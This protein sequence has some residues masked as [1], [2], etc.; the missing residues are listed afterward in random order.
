MKRQYGTQQFAIGREEE[1]IKKSLELKSLREVAKIYKVDD[2][3]VRKFLRKNNIRFKKP[4]TRWTDS[5]QQTLIN[6]LNEGKKHTEI[7]VLMNR[8]ISTVRVRSF[9][10]GFFKKA[11]LEWKPEEE[12]EFLNLLKQNHSPDEISWVLRKTFHSMHK[13]IKRRQIPHDQYWQI[14]KIIQ[15]SGHGSGNDLIR[16]LKQRFWT[17]KKNARNKN[18]EI[19]ITLKY[20]IELY[21]KQQGKCHYTG[22]NMEGVIGSKNSISVDRIDSNKGYTKDNVCLAM[23]K[24]NIA[25]NDL[26]TKEFLEMCYQVNDYNRKH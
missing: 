7:C 13:L 2:E 24:I 25:K 18:I 21:E 3:T 16:T 1:I 11:P 9:A 5:E 6:Y 19:D 12:V 4:N 22:L 14:K 8:C 10:L 26:D 23:I 17:C 20:L 15:R